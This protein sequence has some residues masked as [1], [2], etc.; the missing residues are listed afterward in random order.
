MFGSYKRQ[1]AKHFNNL[2]DCSRA[3]ERP[4]RRDYIV[5]ADGRRG[6]PPSCVQLEISG[7]KRLKSTS[8]SCAC[9]RTDTLAESFLAP[10]RSICFIIRHMKETLDHLL[11]VFVDLL[12]CIITDGPQG[13]QGSSG[14]SCKVK[15][16]SF[17]KTW[18]ESRK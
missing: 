5:R 17:A 9:T 16:L 10:G 15:A 7:G 11:H 2:L 12:H 14:W 13:T 6:R 18:L 3:T 4:R 8:P 1:H